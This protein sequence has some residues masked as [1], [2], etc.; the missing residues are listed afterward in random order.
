MRRGGAFTGA[1]R[2]RHAG[3]DALARI[4]ALLD[5][6][7]ARPALREA[8]PGVSELRSRALLHFHDDDGIFADVRLAEAF[9]R[10]RVATRS[11]QADRLERIDGR[12]SAVESR[13]AAGRRRGER[14]RR[15]RRDARHWTER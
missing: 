4:G 10:V 15:S 14:R 8:R 13:A 11:E 6:L 2:V 3:P 7:R 5:A 12:P 1:P 9:L